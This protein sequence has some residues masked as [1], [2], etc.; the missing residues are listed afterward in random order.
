MPVS[1]SVHVLFAVSFVLSFLSLVALSRFIGQKL[2]E[3]GYD[4]GRLILYGLPTNSSSATS[5]P[6]AGQPISQDT[7]VQAFALVFALVTGAFVFYKFGHSS[8]CS[9]RSF[10]S[11]PAHSSSQDASLYLIPRNGSP[12]LSR[13]KSSSRQTQP[14]TSHQLTVVYHKFF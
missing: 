11:L 5:Q 7:L 8:Q 13:R 2:R 9:I 12:S 4:V 3:A 10:P 1:P 14:C 6:M